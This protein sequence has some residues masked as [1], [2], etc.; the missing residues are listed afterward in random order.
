VLAVGSGTYSVF[1]G[2]ATAYVTHGAGTYPTIE[3]RLD[4]LEKN[5]T[6]IHERISQ[7]QKEMDG[8]FQ[9]I[10]N[11]VKREEQLRQTEDNAIRSKLEATGTG[12]VHISAIG[13]SWL[14]VGII[15]STAATEIAA[16]LE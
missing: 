6:S 5:V 2:K 13:A 10:T 12:G 1:G 11:A 4:A 9:K 8:E 7:T 3:T 14:F 15:L 16:L